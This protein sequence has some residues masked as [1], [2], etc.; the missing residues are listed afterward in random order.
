MRTSLLFVV[1]L[2]LSACTGQ[3]VVPPVTVETP[4]G[5]RPTP[6]SYAATVQSGGWAL[7]TKSEAL[8]CGAWTFD[9]DVNGPY[10]NAMRDVLTRSLEKVTFTPDILTADQLRA[11]GYDAQVVIH[12]GSADASFGVTPGFFTA[13]ARGSVALSVILA[14]RDETGVAYQNTVTGKGTGTKEV[15][16]C[17]SIGEAIG[18]GAQ[19]AI[20]TIVTQIVLYMRDGL[21]SRQLAKRPG[22]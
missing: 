16:G 12:Q 2:V 18:A 15:F 3:A 1:G 22:S 7:E 13:S 8:S 20:Q 11:Q 9:T 5:M 14:I 10:E 21:N 17:P 4:I 6:G 19:D